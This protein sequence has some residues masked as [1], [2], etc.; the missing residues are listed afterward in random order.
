MRI[1][2]HVRCYQRYIGHGVLLIYFCQSSDGTAKFVLKEIPQDFNIRL[3]IYRRVSSCP[4]VRALSDTVP[5]RQMFVFQYLNENL[6]H[7]AQNDL[8]AALRKQVLKCALRGLAALH[9]QDI[10]HNGENTL[11]LRKR[12]G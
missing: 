1:S 11:W 5:D 2:C 6:L 10:V 4:H 7:L 3:G 8:S 9:E 12:Q